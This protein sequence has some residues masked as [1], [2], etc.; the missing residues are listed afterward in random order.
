MMQDTDSE[1]NRI[2]VW[3]VGCRTSLTVNEYTI[4]SGIDTHCKD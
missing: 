2:T 4:R 3:D 1:D